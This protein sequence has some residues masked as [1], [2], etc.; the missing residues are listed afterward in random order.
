LGSKFFDPPRG[1]HQGLY[2][3]NV[4]GQTYNGRVYIENPVN[5]IF[6]LRILTKLQDL[7]VAELM[8]RPLDEV[9]L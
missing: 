7:D 9:S 8:S 6:R 2:V 5:D 3:P 4:T 1:R